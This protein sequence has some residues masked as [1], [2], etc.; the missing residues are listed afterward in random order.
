MPEIRHDAPRDAPQDQ[1]GYKCD[2][3]CKCGRHPDRDELDG[4]YL[5]KELSL[6]EYADRVG[7]DKKSVQRHVTGHLSEA[8]LKATEIREV[9][10]ADNLLDQ[11]K[12]AREKALSFLGKAENA[13]DTRA[14][15]PPSNYLREIREQIK[16]WAELEGKL[17][18]QPQIN[19][20]VNPQWIE[21]RTLILNAL[22]PYPEAR[23]AVVHA[24]RK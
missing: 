21:L 17:A 15:G 16:L 19:I 12:T 23:E 10:N 22:E 1:H 8:L 5:R 14:Y 9:A 4:A 2:A 7:C 11:L 3:R 13:G 20:L 6:Q 18:A 24:I